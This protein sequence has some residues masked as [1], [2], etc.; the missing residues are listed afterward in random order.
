[1]SENPIFRWNLELQRRFLQRDLCH[2]YGFDYA[3]FI[4]ARE[5]LTRLKTTREEIEYGYQDRADLKKA[6]DILEKATA[7]GEFY[8]PNQP[9]D[10][11]GRCEVDP[12]HETT[13]PL[14]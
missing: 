9:R 5:T 7:I 11:K 10:A 6:R 1:M 13:S 14:E 2:L 4:W 8:D 3:E 12:S